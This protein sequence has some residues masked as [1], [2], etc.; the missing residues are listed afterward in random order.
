MCGHCCS[1][2]IHGNRVVRGTSPPPAAEP[3]PRRVT[4]T[5]DRVGLADA[6]L[7]QELTEQLDRD[8]P[9]LQCRVCQPAPESIDTTFAPRRP[10]RPASSRTNAATWAF[11][12]V[13][14]N[15]T[16]WGS[17]H[18]SLP[19]VPVWRAVTIG[20]LPSGCTATSATGLADGLPLVFI[21]KL[22]GRRFTSCYRSLAISD[23]PWCTW[24]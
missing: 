5:A 16:V 18:G 14:P 10:S 2:G 12:A 1:P 7:H 23:K 3:T 8:Q 11:G 19:A 20:V 17:G 4:V 21:S 15:A 6:L 22:C 13:S 9:L 24:F